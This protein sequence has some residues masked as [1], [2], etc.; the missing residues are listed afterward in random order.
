MKVNLLGN[1]FTNGRLFENTEM[2]IKIEMLS[3]ERFFF[4]KKLII[5]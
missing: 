3:D 4:Y 2:S 5:T 1:G